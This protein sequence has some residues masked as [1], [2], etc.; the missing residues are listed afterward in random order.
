MLRRAR[1]RHNATVPFKT[2][3]YRP[4]FP[5]RFTSI[6][7]A[8]AHCQEF[9]RWYNDEHRSPG[10]P[11]PAA[12][13]M[14]QVVDGVAVHSISDEEPPAVVAGSQRVSVMRTPNSLSCRMVL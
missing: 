10:G 2:L 7:H 1:R 5:A 4:Y 9:F 14:R 12:R 13:R 6:E 11:Q 3:K 8:R